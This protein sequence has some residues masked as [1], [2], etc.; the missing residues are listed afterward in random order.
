[1][2]FFV[3]FNFIYVNAVMKIFVQLIIIIFITL[4]Q[5]S[6]FKQ[7]KGKI[8]LISIAK[9]MIFVISTIKYRQRAIE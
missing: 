1:M 4:K 5:C 3:N 9:F 8:K 7:L 6:I 2:T